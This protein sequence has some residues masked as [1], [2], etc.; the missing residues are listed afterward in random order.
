[1]KPFSQKWRQ[2]LNGLFGITPNRHEAEI[3]DWWF[4]SESR[5]VGILGGERSGKSLES[6]R[7]AAPCIRPDDVG[8]EYWIVGPD[9]NQARPEFS[10]LYDAFQRGGLIRGESSMPMSGSQAWSFTTNW[11]AVV[12]TRSA[13][14]VTKLASFSVYGAIMAE[15][16]QN[17]HE[18][19][20]KLLGRVSETRGFLILSGTLEDGLPWYVDLHKRWQGPN[21]LGAR[22]FSLPT[23]SNIDI[24]PGGRQ[25]PAIKELEAEYPPDLFMERFGAIPSIHHLAVIPEFN[26]EKHVKKLEFV[27]DVP[28]ELWV[29][30]GKTVYAVLFVQNIGLYT[31]VLDRVYAR[32]KIAQDVIP[33]VVANPL[34]QAVDKSSAGVMDFAGNQ[35][36]G[37]KSQIALW[38]EIANCSFRF[39]YIPEQVTIDTIRFRLRDTNNYG[40]PLVFFNSHF[41]NAKL[42]NGQA[43][44][45]LAE[46]DLW[47]YPARSMKQN[48]APGPIDSN[49][50]ALKA[51]GYGLVDKFGAHL[52]KAKL[53]R[54]RKTPYWI[55]V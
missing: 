37:N 48:E 40:E 50:H 17:P 51:L 46:F 52:E 18:V 42:A 6:A 9:Y 39:Q 38:K 2:T 13:A 15:A 11:G 19:Y 22:S 5:V 43:L 12:R 26:Y 27:P 10:Y 30:P 20:M 49:N 3:E 23:W 1:M 25:D 54:G 4:N 8:A 21:I 53:R 47:R 34:F 24:Y 7:L 29:D 16:A 35:E 33:D 45:V 55:P 14:D 32:N 44:D 36:H 41:T 28:V 31:H